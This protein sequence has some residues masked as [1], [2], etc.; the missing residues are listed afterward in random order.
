MPPKPVNHTTRPSHVVARSVGL[1][2]RDSKAPPE[3]HHK[4]QTAQGHP[5][6]GHPPASPRPHDQPPRQGVW[7][8]LPP[9]PA[10]Q[11]TPLK[12]SLPLDQPS[13]SSP[14]LLLQDFTRSPGKHLGHQA[15]RL[16]K[17]VEA[18]SPSRRRHRYSHDNHLE[19]SP[20]LEKNLSSPQATSL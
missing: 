11:Q 20:R 2:C 10:S 16:K 4:R 17:P 9:T 13:W 12:G 14:V 7:D 3:S 5:D 1:F 19:G 8:H 15:R 18:L 6:P